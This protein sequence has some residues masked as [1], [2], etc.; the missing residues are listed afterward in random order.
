M[1]EAFS[2]GQSARE[3]EAR[4]KRQSEVADLRHLSVLDDP[5]ETAFFKRLVRSAVGTLRAHTVLDVGCGEGIPT[6]AAVQAGAERAIGIDLARHNVVQAREN[7]R[8]AGLSERVRFRCVDF[9]KLAPDDSD[10]TI[11]DLVVANPPYVPDG[12]GSA[13][14]GGPT[15]TA[16]L[17]AIIDRAGD[18]VRGMALL[19]GSLSDPLAVLDRLDARGFVPCQVTV[20]PVPF[21]RYTSRPRTL[22]TLRRLR[23]LGKAW[24]CDAAPAQPGH[25]PHAYL[26]LGIVASREPSRSSAAS[27]RKSLAGLLHAYGQQS[28][29]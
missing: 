3:P 10:L 25:A 6:L 7:A 20:L 2:A 12:H 24:F 14:D 13:V 5:V 27:A 29:S 9:G 19:F 17:D 26:T 1:N 23:E 16:L 11:C 21:G 18:N 15:G 4:P 22:C 28:R 8:R